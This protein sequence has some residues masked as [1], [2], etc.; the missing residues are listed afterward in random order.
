VPARKREREEWRGWQ[1]AVGGAIKTGIFLRLDRVS[2][3]GSLTRHTRNSGSWGEKCNFLQGVFL[4]HE[5]SAIGESK[6]LKKTGTPFIVSNGSGE[7]M[8]FRRRER[9]CFS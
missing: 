9:D 8:R 4:A 5:D 2:F 6:A 7:K 3:A 1:R